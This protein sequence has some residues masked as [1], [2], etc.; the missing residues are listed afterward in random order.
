MSA[1]VPTS[2]SLDRQTNRQLTRLGHSTDLA[3]AS[4]E[5]KAQIEAA[6]VHAVSY[7]GSQAMHA[8]AMVSQ[9]EYQLGQTCPMA[10]TR[11][12]GI[13]DITALSVAEVVAGSVRRIA[14]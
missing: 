11:L 5:S 10:V 8:V 4:V 3:I 14:R 1:L 12:Q 7:V 9:L 2:G 6:K 13:A